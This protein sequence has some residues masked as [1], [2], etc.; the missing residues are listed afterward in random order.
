M[1]DYTYSNIIGVRIVIMEGT[2]IKFLQKFMPELVGK[3]V[4]LS[5][6]RDQHIIY[7]NEA[8]RERLGYAKPE[9]LQFVHPFKLSPEKQPSGEL[10]STKSM[11]MMK[12]AKVLGKFS[13][14]WVHLTADKVLINCQIHLFDISDLED[15]NHSA[16]DMFAVW[17]FE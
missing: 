9:Q 1:P 3:K 6:N 10:S 8:I 13:F 12:K 17:Q 11:L 16:I 7:T 2:A 14:P 15:K 5:F 4:G